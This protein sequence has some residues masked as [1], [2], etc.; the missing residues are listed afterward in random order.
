MNKRAF[1]LAGRIVSAAFVP[2]LLFSAAACGPKQVESPIE[3]ETAEYVVYPPAPDTARVQFL[4]RYA[5]AEDIETEDG[6]SFL[7]AIVGNDPRDSRNQIIYKPYGVSMARGTI[8]TCDTML[9]AVIV[10]DVA[11]KE[12]AVLQPTEGPGVLL[13]PINCFADERDGKLYVADVGR[14]EVLVFDSTLAHESTI[15]SGDGLHRPI[16]VQ[17]HGD[18][19][20]VAD[21]VGHRVVAFDRTTL[22]QVGKIPNIGPETSEGIRQPTNIWV[23]DDEVYVSD[24]GDFQVK[25][26]SHDGDFIRAVGKY[27]RGFGMFV[28]PKGIAVDRDGILYVVDAGFQ[29]VQMFNEQGEVLMFFGGPSDSPGAMY[30]PAKVTI[31]YENLDLYRDLVDPSLEMKHLIIV[32]NQYGANKINVYARVEPKLTSP[33]APPVADAD[34]ATATE[35]EPGGQR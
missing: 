3:V 5:G 30:L 18:R 7:D 23:T 21:Q 9:Q 16:D 29:N 14:G 34:P 20:W 11:G 1:H 26:Y 17:V 13:K 2:C 35:G 28:R 12:L 31:D 19:I 15:G 6:G 32:T 22:E 10:M 4:A 27:G 33:S 8:Y 25:V 24:F